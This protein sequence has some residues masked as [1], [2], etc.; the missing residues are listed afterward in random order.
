MRTPRL[1]ALVALPACA[2]LPIGLAVAAPAGASAGAAARARQVATVTTGVTEWRSRFTSSGLPERAFLV[3]VDLSRATLAL[4]AASPDELIGA[5]RTDIRAQ[6]TATHA[7]AG[8]N[9]DWFDYASPVAIPRGGLIRAGHVLKTPRPGW[10]ANLY[11]RSGGVAAIGAIPFT[12]L[13]T[14]AARAGGTH[15]VSTRLYSINTPID[16]ELGRIT[17]VTSDAAALGFSRSCTVAEGSTGARG[18]VVTR[19]ETAVRTL[20]RRRAGQFALVSCGGSG[21][22]WLRSHLRAHDRISLTT[23]FPNGKPSVAV[24]GGRVL[25]EGGRAYDDVGGQVLRGRNPETF[26]CVS[27]SGRSLLLGVVDGRSRLSAGVTHPQ[28]QK[29]LLSLH[30]WSAM[31]FDGGGSSTIVARMPGHTGVSVLNVPSDGALRPVADGLF[32]YKR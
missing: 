13:I 14:R 29:Y 23:A 7:L 25:I 10:D 28:L 5:R 31:T 16:A 12:G 4:N 27:R 26:A 2:L 21:A 32:V 11:L 9:A 8:I 1:V 17:L 30:C 22:T 3:R 15:A 18:R 20:P 6:A 24:S 19:V